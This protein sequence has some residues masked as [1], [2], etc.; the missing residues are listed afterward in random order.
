M[1][2]SPL[3]S[4]PQPSQTLQLTRPCATCSTRVEQAFRPAVRPRIRGAALAA[5]VPFGSPTFAKLTWVPQRTAIQI[6]H[7]RRAALPH[8]TVILSECRALAP[9][10]GRAR[11]ESKSPVVPPPTKPNPSTHPTVRHVQ[12]QGRAGLQACCKATNKGCG[13]S[14]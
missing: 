2:L 7:P 1:S 5:E 14:R 10:V 9:G 12:H 3:S 11:H 4:L 8:T 6:G 13:L